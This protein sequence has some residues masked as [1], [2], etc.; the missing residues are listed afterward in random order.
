MIPNWQI[1]KPEII[2]TQNNLLTSYLLKF[3]YQNLI[4]KIIANANTK[5]FNLLPAANA[6]AKIPISKKFLKEKNILM[7]GKKCP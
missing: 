6:K 2:N 1:K 4:K 3:F 7:Q 5:K